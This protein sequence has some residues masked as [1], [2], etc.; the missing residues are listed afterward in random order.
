VFRR[1]LLTDADDILD[2]RIKAVGVPFNASKVIAPIHRPRD[3][4]FARKSSPP[5][6][7]IACVR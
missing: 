2:S 7:C 1:R 3:N 4:R 6:A 5:T